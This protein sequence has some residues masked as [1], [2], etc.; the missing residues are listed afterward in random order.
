MSVAVSAGPDEGGSGQA[1]GEAVSSKGSAC[2]FPPIEP[3]TNRAAAPTPLHTSDPAV[4]QCTSLPDLH[5]ATAKTPALQTKAASKRKELFKGTGLMTS[6]FSL[7][8][9]FRGYEY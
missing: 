1:V 3:S 8:R 2:L 4:S 7:P 9:L 6:G 5:P